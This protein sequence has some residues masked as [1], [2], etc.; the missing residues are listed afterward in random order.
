M[1]C[2][3]PLSSICSILGRRGQVFALF[4]M[5]AFLVSGC[6]GTEMSRNAIQ[7]AIGELKSGIGS[8]GTE[9]R[10]CDRDPFSHEALTADLP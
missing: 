6:L 4:A 2:S 7:G 10:S 1:E 3:K 9:V 8:A 5:L